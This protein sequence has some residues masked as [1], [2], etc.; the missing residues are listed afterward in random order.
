MISISQK[1]R[2]VLARR[3]MSRRTLA[4]QL[5][6]SSSNYY[7]KE[8]RDNWK[9]N[10]IFAIAEALNCDVEINFILKDTEEKF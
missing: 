5:N 6:W 7:N 1:I 9:M 2:L 4:K 3:D 10:E 8:K